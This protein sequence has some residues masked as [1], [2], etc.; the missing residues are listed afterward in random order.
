[1]VEKNF[2]VKP[3]TMLPVINLIWRGTRKSM[4]DPLPQAILTI[5]MVTFLNPK[6]CRAN[7]MKRGKSE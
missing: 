5:K 4:T 1:M 6:T 2:A 7:K 3:V